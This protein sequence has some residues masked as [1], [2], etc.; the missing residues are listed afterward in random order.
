MD[1]K[2]NPDIYKKKVRSI[3]DDDIDVDK[4]A[5]LTAEERAKL[6]PNDYDKDGNAYGDF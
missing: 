3:W 5:K 1:K 4:L 6:F 2:K